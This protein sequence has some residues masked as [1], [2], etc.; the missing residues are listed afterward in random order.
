MEDEWE[1]LTPRGMAKFTMRGSP[2]S[3]FVYTAR[4]K[5]DNIVHTFH[6][7]QLSRTE[8]EERFAEDFD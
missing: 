8:I 4:L 7:R 6:D 2:E 5:G 1:S 3:G